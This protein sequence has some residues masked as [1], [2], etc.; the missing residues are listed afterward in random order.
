MFSFAGSV[1]F[2]QILTGKCIGKQTTLQTSSALQHADIEKNLF[3]QT[4]PPAPPSASAIA[5]PIPREEPVTIDTGASTSL[6]GSE[7]N[8]SVAARPCALTP[9]HLTTPAELFKQGLTPRARET[10]RPEQ[11][12]TTRGDRWR[13]ARVHAEEV[14]EAATAVVDATV[15]TLNDDDAVPAIKPRLPFRL[16]FSQQITATKPKPFQNNEPLN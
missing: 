12:R 13:E 14:E 3:Q 16:S 9:N 1:E 5:F 11:G 15:H 10:A 7:T 6:T 8:G 4:F 2:L